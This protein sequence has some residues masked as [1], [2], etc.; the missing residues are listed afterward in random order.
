M[1]NFAHQRMEQLDPFETLHI[2]VT[3]VLLTL[4][5]LRGRNIWD[6]QVLGPFMQQLNLDVEES[7]DTARTLVQQLQCRDMVNPV[8]VA[9]PQWY[10]RTWSG[11]KRLSWPWN[12]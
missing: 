11:C 6:A 2:H 4:S 9:F 7:I 1:G 5:S 8:C 3:A 12:A 10:S